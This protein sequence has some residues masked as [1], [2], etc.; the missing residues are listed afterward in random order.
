MPHK[1]QSLLI[2]WLFL[3]LLYIRVGGLGVFKTQNIAQNV[4]KW[5]GN[6][7]VESLSQC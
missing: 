4:C 3:P 6:D 7:D 1:E 2:E 5:G